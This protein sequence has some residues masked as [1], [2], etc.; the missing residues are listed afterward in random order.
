MA[1]EGQVRRTACG[2]EMY[3]SGATSLF[4]AAIGY[5]TSP[6]GIHWTKDRTNPIYRAADDPVTAGTANVVEGPTVIEVGNERWLYYDY[7]QG[8]DLPAVGVAVAPLSCY[9]NYLPSIVKP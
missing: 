7:G 3:Y 9:A 4:E 1:W 8:D 6:D 5:A 2:W